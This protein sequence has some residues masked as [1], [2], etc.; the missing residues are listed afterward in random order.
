M[1]LLGKGS[2]ISEE[3]FE[4]AVYSLDM[5]QNDISIAFTANLS[6]PQVIDRIPSILSRIRDSVE[7]SNAYVE[8]KFFT[9]RLPSSISKISLVE[10]ICTIRD[11]ISSAEMNI[12]SSTLKSE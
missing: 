9:C 2:M 3:E 6:Y 7:V 4:N 12:G 8:S 10:I 1:I 11:L 5:G